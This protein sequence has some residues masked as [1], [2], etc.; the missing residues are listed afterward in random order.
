M[1]LPG[2][3]TPLRFEQRTDPEPGD[4]EIRVRVSACG[5]CRTDLHVTEGDLPPHQSGVTPGHEV[6]GEVAA[7]GE[8]DTA[9]FEPG[10]RAGA[11]WLR[12][13]DNTCKFCRRDAENLCPASRYTGW[14]ADGGYAEYMTVP[15]AYAHRL[16]PGYTNE[17][18]APLL[19][20]G[21][22]GY[23]A[24]QRAELPDHGRLG[25]YGFGGSA[26]LATQVALA[27]GATVHVLTR[28]EQAKQLARELGAASVG[29]ADGMPP[30][31]LDAAILFAPVGDLV[32]PAMAALD[33]GGT[34]SIAGIH[35]TDIPP[36]NYEKHL[37]QERQ[38]RSVTS[39]TRG[40]A[41]EFLGFAAEHKLA[42]TVHPYPL[43]A[44][45]QA[46]R[47]LKAGRFDGAAV[48]VP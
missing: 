39:N 13:T 38:L 29:D 1:V 31:P 23:R 36:L 7:V 47:D 2:P 46:L 40:D 34:L 3:R 9:G 20:A 18:L 4:G 26:H 19:C 21:I 44:A 30:E 37:F 6:V 27:R 32:L 45:D 25:I 22:I 48:L 35:L 11:A 10:D 33:R 28:G 43:D 16:P 8:G 12:S 42:V 24:L 14:D 41:R 15:A 5:V 17:E